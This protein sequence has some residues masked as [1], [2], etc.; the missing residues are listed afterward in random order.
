MKRETGQA[1]DSFHGYGTHFND[2][3]VLG[4]DGMQLVGRPC[5]QIPTTAC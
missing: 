4:G 2:Q 1:D 3:S 5:L